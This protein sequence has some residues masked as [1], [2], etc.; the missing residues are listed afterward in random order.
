MEPLLSISDPEFDLP[1]L[2][3]PASS[4]GFTKRLVVNPFLVVIDWLIAFAILRASIEQH[5]FILCQ[6]G[7][8]VLFFGFLLLQ[9]HCLDCGRTGWLLRHRR[10]A[11]PDG[12]VSWQGRRRDRLSVPGIRTQ[13]GIWCVVIATVVFLWL[14]LTEA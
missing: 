9:Y 11:C 1:Q 14:I 5:S 6:I 13:V 2:Q 4:R 10:H 8:M 7:T 12:V 3:R